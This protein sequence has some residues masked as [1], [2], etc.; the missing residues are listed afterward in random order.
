M[1]EPLFHCVDCGA[2]ATAAGSCAVCDGT[3]LDVTTADGMIAAEDADDRRRD[4]HTN[5]NA[6]IAIF[7]G[8][9][10]AP[11]AI[12]ALGWLFAMVL[13]CG[14]AG[15]VFVALKSIRPYKTPMPNFDTIRRL[16]SQAAGNGADGT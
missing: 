12:G 3:V 14:V 8:V 7:A 6:F 15:L 11:F 16:Q 10:S 5:V 4:K 9:A 13:F 1:I 2:K